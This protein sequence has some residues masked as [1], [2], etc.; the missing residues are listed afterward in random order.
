MFQKTTSTEQCPFFLRFIISATRNS[1]P[2]RE[3]GT[4]LQNYTEKRSPSEW[5]PCNCN[6]KCAPCSKK[7]AD[8]RRRVSDAATPLW[9]QPLFVHPRPNAL[10]GHARSYLP[11][12]SKD[13]SDELAM[14]GTNFPTSTN[15]PHRGIEFFHGV[16]AQDPTIV[17]VSQMLRTVVCHSDRPHVPQGSLPHTMRT[18]LGSPCPCFGE[19]GLCSSLRHSRWATL[20]RHPCVRALETKGAARQQLTHFSQSFASQQFVR[21]CLQPQ[22]CIPMSSLVMILVLVLC[23]PSRSLLSAQGPDFV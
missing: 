5:A 11:D 10:V 14:S 4:W 12:S 21:V 7:G 2:P 16:T 1:T 18:S 20:G 22:A 6:K 9:Q 17:A 19:L 3:K 15:S 13:N 23:H 8:K